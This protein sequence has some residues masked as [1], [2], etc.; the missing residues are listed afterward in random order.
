[1]KINRNVGILFHSKAKTNWRIVE[2]HS[3]QQLDV[4]QCKLHGFDH[5]LMPL[6]VY[7]PINSSTVQFKMKT[8]VKILFDCKPK[9]K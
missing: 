4:W 2:Y 9:T 6:L 8:N 1:M 5:V 3:N 7:L